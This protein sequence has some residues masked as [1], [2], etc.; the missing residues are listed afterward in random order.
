MPKKQMAKP[1]RRTQIKDQS[2]KEKPLSKNELKQ[3]KG[4][5]NKI[6]AINIK[7]KVVQDSVGSE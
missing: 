6:E 4:G 7:Q 1:Q 5:V 3:V 2:K